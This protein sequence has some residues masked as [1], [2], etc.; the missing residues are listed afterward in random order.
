MCKVNPTHK[1]V[2]LTNPVHSD[3]NLRRRWS[4]ITHDF[5]S[6]GIYVTQHTR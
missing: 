3:F 4:G 5:W 2:A 1:Y 6:N